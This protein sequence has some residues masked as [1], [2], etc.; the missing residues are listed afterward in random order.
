MDTETEE[1]KN[2]NEKKTERAAREENSRGNQ[3]EIRGGVRER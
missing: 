3:M 1:R 2:P